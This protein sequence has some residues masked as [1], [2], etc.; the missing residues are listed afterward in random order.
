MK[1]SKP[2]VAIDGPAGSGKTTVAWNV[3]QRLGFTLVDT[4]AIYRCLALLARREQVPE[5]DGAALAAL[6]GRMRIRLSQGE[7]RLRVWLNDEE[8]TEGIRE[9]SI[10][11]A[12]SK[13]SAHPPVRGALLALQREL[14][15][16]GG[17]VL[18]GRDIGTVV[19]PDA[20]VKV[21]LRADPQVRARRRTLELC[22]KGL[23]A[24]GEQTLREI[25]ERDQRDEQR[26]CAPLVAAADAVVI[27][28]GPLTLAQVTAEVL[29]LVQA[30]VGQ[31][32]GLE[33][34]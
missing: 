4:G 22:A 34:G 1:R 3:A 14:G 26:A 24:D 5:T 23:V 20:E 12:A 8:V 28:T 19:F 16:N 15:K 30:C 9:P 25:R 32:S 33:G 10:S 17:V 13:V 7:G 31:A 11:Q 2:V 27:D 21:F 18:E 6:V 29:G